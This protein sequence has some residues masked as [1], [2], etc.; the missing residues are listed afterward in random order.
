MAIEADRQL[1]TALPEYY[2]LLCA[3]R[4][5]AAVRELVICATGD[6]R[7]QP[8]T[9]L[10]YIL[11]SGLIEFRREIERRERQFPHDFRK[12]LIEKDGSIISRSISREE[13]EILRYAHGHWTGVHRV[14]LKARRDLTVSEIIPAIRFTQPFPAVGG[15]RCGALPAQ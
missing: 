4:Y 13:S 5:A 9:R 10:C 8:T 1:W 14:A 12:A 7:Q 2:V 15:V 11:E 6:A 3:Q